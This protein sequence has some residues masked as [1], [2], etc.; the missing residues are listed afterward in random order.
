MK[1]LLVI[2]GILIL[3]TQCVFAQ[4]VNH[5]YE[6]YERY[7]SL[8]GNHWTGGGWLNSQDWW[9]HDNW[10]NGIPD[11]GDVVYMVPANPPPF[12]GYE[13][14][15]VYY[16]DAFHN[17]E[18]PPQLQSLTIDLG[19]TLSRFL[20]N[21]T[22]KARE[23]YIGR[24]STGTFLQDGGNNYADYLYLGYNE[25]SVGNYQINGGVN[26][27]GIPTSNL[28]VDSILRVGCNSGWVGNE[29]VAGGDGNFQQI[30]GNIYADYEFVGTVQG[31]EGVF[32]QSGG[33]SYNGFVSLVIQN[34]TY[35]L[36]DGGVLEG[37]REV[38]GGSEEA[39]GVFQ[40]DGGLNNCR[41]I[42][43]F[44]HGFYNLF[45]LNNN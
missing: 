26:N 5:D 44:G 18:N 9:E 24:Y 38:L 25:G 37:R 33:V 2:L 40:Q 41:N 15:E 16:T 31:S 36:G 7:W 3:S 8:G 39:Y 34:G 13:T 29:L 35:T 14:L 11:E 10:Y 20:P 30:N 27:A 45:F 6:I 4:V 32:N 28:Y 12:Q 19:M 23:Q 22:L 21:S 1:K 42:E 17:A 43:F